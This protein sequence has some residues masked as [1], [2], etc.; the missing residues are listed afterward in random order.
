MID[1]NKIIFVTGLP[2]LYEMVAN[3]A[4]GAIVKSIENGQ[5]KF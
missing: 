2:G 5:T 4:D 1:L 3:R